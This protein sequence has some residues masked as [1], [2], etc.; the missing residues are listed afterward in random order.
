M[1]LH[2]FL[3]RSAACFLMAGFLTSVSGC[4]GGGGSS[5]PPA[6]VLAATVPVISTQPL[7]MQT[8]AQ[9]GTASFTITATGNG[10]LSYQWT[11]GGSNL[12][13]GTNIV[14]ATT[15]SLSLSNLQGS[16]AGIYACLVT[17]TLSGTTASAASS[18]GALTVVPLA[19][20]HFSVTGFPSPAASGTPHTFTVTALDAQ[21]N[22]VI[23]HAGTVHFTST[24]ATA[25]LPG[26]Y[27]FV[28]A[29]SGTHAFT[30]TL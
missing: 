22:A 29:D 27:T 16:D 8:I 20:T 5:T 13:N 3:Y 18:G 7:A 1:F 11:K 30:A 25:V 21:N 9:G 6:P 28:G 14:G 17:N 26:D 12:A 19:A 4:G 10:I 15:G 2:R 23:G 24:D